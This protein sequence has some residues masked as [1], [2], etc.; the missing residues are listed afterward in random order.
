MQTD[1][2][3]NLT[4]RKHGPGVDKTVGPTAIEE[5]NTKQDMQSLYQNRPNQN[6]D[7]ETAKIQIQNA[8]FTWKLIE[9]K[10]KD[11]AGDRQIPIN[12][13]KVIPKPNVNGGKSVLSND[14]I[15][16]M[17]SSV[18]S[19]I[20]KVL[21]GVLGKNPLIPDRIQVLFSG[22]G[23]P[24]QQAWYVEPGTNQRGFIILF[25]RTKMMA[26]ETSNPQSIAGFEGSKK[27]TNT[28]KREKWQEATAIHE[29]GHMLNLD[30]QGFEFGA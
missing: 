12:Y 24:R 8:N 26:P 14:E 5:R 3:Y 17:Q 13:W 10:V 2:G 6:A 28:G 22:L 11:V 7:W 21:R 4:M 29:M 19:G 27:Y 30:V 15:K 18:H 9:R 23:N 20:K 1:D 16:E 25:K